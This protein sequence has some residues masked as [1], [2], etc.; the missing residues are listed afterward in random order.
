MGRLNSHGN[1]TCHRPDTIF[2]SIFVQ[3][4][5]HSVLYK[6]SLDPHLVCVCVCVC[7]CVRACVRA[8][9]RVCACVCAC[10]C[11]C[12]CVV[13]VICCSYNP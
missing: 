9:V 1:F 6:A 13:C 11:V 8:C 12:V 3:G 10:V 7:V 4:K 2:S 5:H